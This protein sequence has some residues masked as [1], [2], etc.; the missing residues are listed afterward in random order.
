MSLPTL[1]E[2]K[3]HLRIPISQTAQDALLSDKLTQAKA[4]VQ[5]FIGTPITAVEKTFRD[6]AETA[7]VYG[8]ITE[9][10]LS[11]GPI[12]ADEEIVVTD[13]DGETVPATDYEVDGDEAVIRAAAGVTFSNG[14]YE[15]TATVGL[16]ADADYAADIEPVIRQ[17]ILDFAA[18]LY[19]NRNTSASSES[20][21]G[22]VSISR[23]LDGIPG[24]ML[25]TL[26]GLRWRGGT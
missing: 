4:R 7:Q 20:A 17:A 8:V 9:L 26:E 11:E 23:S 22:G 10:M 12:D 5:R 2:L 1:N 6:A 21:G 18:D 25:S 14:P 3:A 13:A 16:S 15:I 19:Q 24:R